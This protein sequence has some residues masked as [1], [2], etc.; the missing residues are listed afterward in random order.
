[1]ILLIKVKLYGVIRLSAGV[2]QF[3]TNVAT[4]EELKGILP[5]ISRKEANDLIVLVNGNPVK[6]N[7]RFED[8]DEVVFL[9]PAGGG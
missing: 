3:E 2:S 9:A 1:M 7:Y 6:K 8:A 5:G 4:L